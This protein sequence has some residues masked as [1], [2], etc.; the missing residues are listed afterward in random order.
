MTEFTDPT[1]I[2]FSPGYPGYYPPN[3]NCTYTIRLD[4]EDEPMNLELYFPLLDI[5]EE[6]NCSYDALKISNLMICGDKNGSSLTCGYIIYIK[7]INVI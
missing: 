1:G 7:I 3:L 5:E 4:D 2:I 6:A